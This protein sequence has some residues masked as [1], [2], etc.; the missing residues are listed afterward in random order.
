MLKGSRLNRLLNISRWR[1]RRDDPVPAPTRKS[2]ALVI[3]LDGTMS[4]LSPGCETNAGL[5]YRLMQ[6]AGDDVSLFYEPGIQWQNWRSLRDVAIGRGLN[7]QIR[8]AYRWLARNYHPGD[9]IYL[10]GY[11]RGGFAVRSLAG[12]IDRMGLLRPSRATVDNVRA[13]YNFYECDPQGER[14]Q[15][16]AEA[17]CHRHVDIEFVG[18][19]DTVKA[20]GIRLPL[21]W[22]LTE[23][24]HAFHSTQLGHCVKRGR[25]ALALDETRAV[26]TPVMWTTAP[27][28]DPDR[29]E[30]V[31]FRGTHGDIGGQL[32]GFAPARGLSNIPLTWLLEEAEAAGLDLPSGWRL[33]FP[34]D[35]EAPS[36]GTWRGIGRIFLIRRPRAV[37]SDPSERLHETAPPL[38]SG[39]TLLS[40]LRPVLPRRRIAK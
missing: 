14:G 39:A 28:E 12:V 26:Y 9:R 4:S 20:L 3:I 34:T 16:F 32:G 2:R 25:H 29:V 1:R 18:A 33:R 40:L 21:I 36:T 35:P 24:R 19:W 22:R 15:L 30:Q 17:Y 7:R 38:A 31:W 27:D 8:R 6:E 37:R 5:A 13:L 10:L 11:S 23:N